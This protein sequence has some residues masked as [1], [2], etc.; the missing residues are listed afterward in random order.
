MSRLVRALAG[1]LAGALARV[2]IVGVGVVVGAHAASC[3]PR[4]SIAPFTFVDAGDIL[5]LDVPRPAASVVPGVPG[6]EGDDGTGSGAVILLMEQ[7]FLFQRLHEYSDQ[8]HSEIF[9]HEAIKLESEAGFDNAHV[10]I[11]WP[12]DGTLVQLDARTI[13]PDGTV[14][15][16]SQAEL[17]ASE[18]KVKK[19][20]Q[21]DLRIF[22]FPRVEVGSI[23]ELAYKIDL[24]GLYTEWNERIPQDL[25]IRAYNVD[26][27]VDAVARPAMR[28]MNAGDVKADETIDGAGMKHVAFSMKNVPPRTSESYSPRWRTREPW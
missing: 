5:R 2:V 24:P 10:Q 23:L 8:E 25:P 1:A 20:F 26:V 14:T 22:E 27:A 3:L 11:A 21:A 17:F 7:H 9:T 18:V 4:Q 28:V 12:K 16:L 6:D 13:A 19:D 15:P